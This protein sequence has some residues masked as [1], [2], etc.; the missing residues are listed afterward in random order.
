MKRCSKMGRNFLLQL[1][2]QTVTANALVTDELDGI[3]ALQPSPSPSSCFPPSLGPPLVALP[4]SALG[5]MACALS[6]HFTLVPFHGKMPS[7][8]VCRL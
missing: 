1:S 5:T 3:Q 7:V 4:V 2:L 8:S 6:A